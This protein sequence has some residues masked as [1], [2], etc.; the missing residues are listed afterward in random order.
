V[1]ITIGP[2]H[3]IAIC[4]MLTLLSAFFAFVVDALI[5]RRLRKLDERNDERYVLRKEMSAI[6]QWKR[7]LERQAGAE[8]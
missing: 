6:P 5:G 8:Y 2:E 7:H 1:T 3:I 4:A